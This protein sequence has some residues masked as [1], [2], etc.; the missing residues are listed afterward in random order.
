MRVSNIIPRMGCC[1][2]QQNQQHQQKLA[3]SA[4]STESAKIKKVTGATYIP[5]VVFVERF[6]HTAFTWFYT[7]VTK[8]AFCDYSSFFGADEHFLPKSGRRGTKSI[9]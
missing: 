7:F 5:D 2:N 4:K 9:I 8:S 1:D 3:E 6:S